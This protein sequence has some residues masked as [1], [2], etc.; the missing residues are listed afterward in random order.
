[1]QSMYS[2]SLTTPL[3]LR[4]ALDITFRLPRNQ[5]QLWQ[6]YLLSSGH[7]YSSS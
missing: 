1:M 7:M 6:Y 5:L 3:H 4:L 2:V